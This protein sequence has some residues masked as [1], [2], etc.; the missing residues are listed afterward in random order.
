MPISN[1]FI[2]RILNAI[3]EKTDYEEDDIDVMRYSLQAI[4]WEIEKIIYLFLLFLFIGFH[5]EFL[6]SLGVIMTI[7]PSAGGFHSST[8]WG[9]FLWT[10]FGFLLAFFVLPL[11][12]FTY[13][14]MALVGMFSISMTFIAT[15]VRSKQ[16]ERIA[17]TSKDKQKKY[18]ATVITIIWFI[19]IFIYQD[20]FLTE[21]V[22]WIIFLQNVQLI[23]EYMRKKLD[24]R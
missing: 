1:F 7:R 15:P 5:W 17:D 12:P 19:L 24:I 14:T 23:I 2:I 4:L 21:P 3:R 16:R 10:L 6:A 13:I 22:M 11:L 8:A 18:R 9:C 20:F